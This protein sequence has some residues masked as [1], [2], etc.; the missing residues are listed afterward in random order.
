MNAEDRFWHAPPGQ[1]RTPDDKSHDELEREAWTRPPMLPPLAWVALSVLV[2]VV[3]VWAMVGTWNDVRYAAGGL[4]GEPLDLGDLRV[5][6]RTEAE[7][8]VP[9]GPAGTWVRL[10]NAVVTYEAGSAEGGYNFFYSPLYRIV[11]RTKKDFPPKRVGGTY[12]V[13][14]HLVPLIARHEIEPQDLTSGFDGEGRLYRASEVPGLVRTLLEY[15]APGI[16]APLDQAWVFLEGETPVSAWPYLLLWAL[17]LAA[18]GLNVR[19][20]V[21]LARA[22]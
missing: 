5:R 11:V 10:A 13:E 7:L 15:Y 4:L 21:R 2:L 1:A 16:H 17:C 6:H 22:R 8:V 18:I 3:A 19:V 20:L 14:D 12:Q 9:V